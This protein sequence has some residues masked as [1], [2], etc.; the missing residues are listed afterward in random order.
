MYLGA[1]RTVMKTVKVF[2]AVMIMLVMTQQIQ[3]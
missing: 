2:A 3:A 1:K